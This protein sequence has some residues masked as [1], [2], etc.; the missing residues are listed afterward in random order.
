MLN[1]RIAA[2]DG[3]ITDLYADRI[4]RDHPKTL[5]ENGMCTGMIMRYGKFKLYTAAD[6]SDNW[7]LPDGSKVYTEDSIADVCPRVDVAKI[8]HHGHYSMTEKLIKALQARVYVSCVWDQLHNVAPVMER[9]TDRSLY[10]GDRIICPG[11][12]PAERLEEDKGK[13]F[14]DDI[15]PSAFDGGHVVITVERGG[16]EYSVSYLTADDESMTVV[17]SMNFRSKGD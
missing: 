8:N 6:F 1:G 9:L 7:K 16:D 4:T 11:I 12:F 17:S 3:T 10:P 14:L 2:E 5:N 13:P 15:E